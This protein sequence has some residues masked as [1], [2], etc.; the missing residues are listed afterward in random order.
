MTTWFTSDLHFRHKK[1]VEYTKRGQETTQENHDSWLIDLWNSQV[2]AG[3]L[4]W[5]TGDFCFSR[6]VD[7]IEDILRKLNGV[8][9]FIKGNH[10][11]RKILTE[12]KK[13]NAISWWGD[14]KEIK[15]GDIPTCLFHFPIASWHKQHY[16]SIHLHG[17]CVDMQTEILTKTGWKTRGEISKGD[18]VWTVNKDSLQAE[19][20]PIEE[21]VDVDYT[22]EVFEFK[23]RSSNFRVTKGHVVP[24]LIDNRLDEILVESI[25]TTPR[26]TLTTSIKSAV[27]IPLSDDMLRLYI[28]MVADGSIKDETKLC[29]IKVKKD[30]KKVYL[31]SLLSR[32]GI[33]FKAYEKSGYISYN[34]YIPEDLL[35]Y[36]IK[37][38]DDRLLDASPEQSDVLVEAY[39]NSD[40]HK[41]KNGVIIYSQKERE[42]DMLQAIFATTGWQSTKYGRYHGLGDN[43]QFQLSVTRN[44]SIAVTSSRLR[45]SNTTSEDFW[46]VKVK[47]QTFISRRDGKVA[48]TGNCHG[49]ARHLPGKILDVGLDSAYN[50]FG[51]HKF[52][53]EED[54]LEYMQ[55]RKIQVLDHHQQRQGE[56]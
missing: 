52:F 51:E 14:Y 1:I 27:G 23:G 3:E 34:F 30:H 13:R 9:H 36:K 10:D 11:D 28:C 26:K 5:H 56:M 8:K 17:H 47:N 35:D 15:L 6:D 42:I 29:R 12:L 46:C 24:F 19:L 54:V 33:P 20:Q 22:G 39:S 2:K 38:L 16:G 43:K 41:Q 50:I 31:S 45:I 7:E 53:T 4:V 44:T 40:G 32:L 25:N 48:V 21:I 49:S 37:G 55:S 18:S